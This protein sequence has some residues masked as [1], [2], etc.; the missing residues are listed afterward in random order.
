MAL[1]RPQRRVPQPDGDYWI[2]EA[3][4]DTSSDASGGGPCRHATSVALAADLPR[5]WAVAILGM[6]PDKE[7]LAAFLNL[8]YGIHRPWIHRVDAEVILHLL[9]HAD[10]EPAR[11]VPAGAKSTRCP[12]NGF[13]TACTCEGNTPI[14]RFG[15]PEPPPATATPYYTGRTGRRPRTLSCRTCPR[16]PAMP[17][18]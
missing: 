7:G 15:L 4:G 3:W 18:S 2:P 6:V 10:R 11:R 8:Q 17:S 9:R 5:T 1:G 13:G 14:T 12:Y 16:V